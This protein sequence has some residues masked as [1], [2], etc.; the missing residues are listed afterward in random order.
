MEHKVKISPYDY[1]VA[2][3]SAKITSGN[4]DE[5]LFGYCYG[6][7][8]KVR[9]DQNPQITVEIIDGFGNKS[10]SVNLNLSKES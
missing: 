8:L 2:V 6:T 3:K 10:G 5:H 4:A 7:N 1:D 9:S